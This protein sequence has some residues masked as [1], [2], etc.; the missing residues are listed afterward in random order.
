MRDEI[1]AWKCRGFCGGWFLHEDIFFGAESATLGECPECGDEAGVRTGFV[2]LEGF[3][4]NSNFRPAKMAVA[5]V[6]SGTAERLLARMARLQ[7]MRNEDD[8]PESISFDRPT[9]DWIPA[10]ADGEPD[11]ALHVS[12]EVP[13]LRVDDESCE[14]MGYK[15]HPGAESSECV[16]FRA[17][18]GD[19]DIHT[20]ALSREDLAGMI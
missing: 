19:E 4:G 11:Y 10:E 3:S 8:P 18:W 14:V 5:L 1:Q 2:A 16:R 20:A 13:V 12:K 6:D 9:V 15:A 17:V 7:V